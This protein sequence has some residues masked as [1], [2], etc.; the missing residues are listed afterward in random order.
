[1][2]SNIETSFGNVEE[3]TNIIQLLYSDIKPIPV[4]IIPIQGERAEAFMEY[5]K[6]VN[7]QGLGIEKLEFVVSVDG[8]CV[9]KSSI[10]DRFNKIIL[11]YV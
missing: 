11:K 9:D 6:T 1:M 3:I 2:I 10:E 8:W 4:L 7:V 5:A